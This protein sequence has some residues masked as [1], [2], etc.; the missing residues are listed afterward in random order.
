MAEAIDTARARVI[1]AGHVLRGP[2]MV[3]RMA[4]PSHRVMSLFGVEPRAARAASAREPASP[5][6]GEPPPL[7]VGQLLREL[8]IHVGRFHA[9]KARP[10]IDVVGEI[11]DPRRSQSGHVYFAL[12][13]AEGRLPCVI[14][15]SQAARLRFA[16][17][18]GLE[19]VVSGR[20]NLWP[21]RMEIQLQAERIV[22]VGHGALALAFEQLKR[23]LS[24]AGLFAAER[25]RPLP[26]LPRRIGVV[27][28]RDAAAWRD[29][30]KVMWMR[31]PAMPVLL[32]PA[33]VQG[34]GAAEELARALRALDRS[35]LCDVILLVRGGGALEDLWA[36]NEKVLALALAEC[37]TPVVTGVGHETDVT[38]VD[39]IADARAATPSHAAAR[40]VPETAALAMRLQEAERRLHA[41]L[42]ARVQ[43]SR[44]R[45]ARAARAMGDPRFALVAPKRR[46]R[47]LREGLVAALRRYAQQRRARVAALERRLQA[48]APRRLL[49]ARRQALLEKAPRLE[50]AWRTQREAAQ[51]RL[52]LLAARLEALSPLAV[53]SRGYSL[54]LRESGSEPRLIAST[55]QV[56]PG[57]RVSLRFADGRAHAQIDRVVSFGDDD[58]LVAS[59]DS[60][61][62]NN[63]GNAD[64]AHNTDTANPED[65]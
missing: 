60:T 50:A 8:Q 28:S 17:E 55:R 33:R 40:A 22:P 3:R 7:S 63:T 27:T 51:R 41:R 12:K 62:S 4:R 2:A 30:L 48:G 36:F 32:A 44:L 56:R 39:F 21:A 42:R 11:S 18:A 54:V 53:L 5:A 37:R 25:K 20:V 65:G 47:V 15:A 14:Y 16:L 35:G 61:P 64:P 52:A 43:E 34:Q 57:D 24:A 9:E 45:V 46:V 31:A 19:V 6:G 29:V 1:A 13:D 23:E 59:G 10:R 58:A 38:I 26:L 49:I